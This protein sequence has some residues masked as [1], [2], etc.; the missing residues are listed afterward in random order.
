L[1]PCLP[2][3]LG[4]STLTRSLELSQKLEENETLLEEAQQEHA[5]EC[6]EWESVKTGLETE[7]TKLRQ[8]I[9]M[10]QERNAVLGSQLEE[11][12]KELLETKSL[13]TTA[14]QNLNASTLQCS[15]LQVP[16]LLPSPSPLC[17]PSLFLSHS[18]S[19]F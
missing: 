4:A 12:E 1:P 8:Q 10:S 15:T 2:V 14:E 6:E 16:A 18:P 3:S 5:Q 11:R 9:A 19:L 13:T 17:L 7:L